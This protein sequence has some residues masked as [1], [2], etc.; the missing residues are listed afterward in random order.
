M[1]LVWIYNY[2]FSTFFFTKN[3]TKMRYSRKAKMFVINGKDR[4]NDN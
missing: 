1:N 3:D 4:K 2:Q